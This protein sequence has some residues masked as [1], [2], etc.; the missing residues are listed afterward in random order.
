[1][2]KNTRNQLEEFN[3]MNIKPEVNSIIP[4]AHT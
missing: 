4:G 1:M 2:D 3:Q